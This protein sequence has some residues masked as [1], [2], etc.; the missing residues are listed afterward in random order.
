MPYPQ[1]QGHWAQSGQ[2]ARVGTRSRLAGAKALG[3]PG[4]IGS[5]ANRCAR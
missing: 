1:F 2:G 5:A 3:V 4:A